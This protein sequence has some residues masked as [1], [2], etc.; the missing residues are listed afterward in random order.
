MASSVANGCPLVPTHSG[1]PRL[2]V[3]P[4]VSGLERSQ[5]RSLD[6]P[7]PEPLSTPTSSS[8]SC[9]PSS[10]SMATASVP[11]LA[12]HINGNGPHLHHRQQERGGGS[13]RPKK[14]FLTFPGRPTSNAYSM[15]V[16]GR[17]VVVPVT[18]VGVTGCKEL[19]VTAYCDYFNKPF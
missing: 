12:E 16:N 6:L 5:E 4:R 19:T 3:T 7:Y 8:L 15:G 17:C 14:S 9:L 11:S 18:F 1:M 13:P 2:A 10:H